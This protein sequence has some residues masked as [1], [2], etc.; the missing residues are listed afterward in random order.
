MP[1]RDLWQAQREA[2]G[3]F[4][5]G[6]RKLANLTLRQLAAAAKVSNPY[7]SQIERGLH[8]PSVRVILAIADALDISAETLL[9]KIGVEP[10]G[11]AES[12][13]PSERRT[14]AATERAIRADP[15][16]SAEQKQALLSVYRSYASV[17]RD[18]RGAARASTA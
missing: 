3:D 5:R 9:T 15:L 16:L 6:Q 2:L 8:E 10:N 13:N 12:P 7:L 1:T 11:S 18:S 17:A 14:T 4:I